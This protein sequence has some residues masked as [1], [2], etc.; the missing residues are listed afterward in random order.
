[1][2]LHGST[3][4]FYSG[5]GAGP[6]DMIYDSGLYELHWPAAADDVVDPDVDVLTADKAPL[7]I[8][9]VAVK[10]VFYEKAP[11][12]SSGRRLPGQ[13]AKPKKLS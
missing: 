4:W 3:T 9:P 1:V 8:P 12:G 7:L 13:L 11:C 5:P 6:S 10:T 2:K